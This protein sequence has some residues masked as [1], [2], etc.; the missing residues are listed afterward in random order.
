MAGVYEQILERHGPYYR[1]TIGGHWSEATPAP[2]SPA[3]ERLLGKNLTQQPE[4]ILD[5]IRA[6][7]S[8]I[9]RE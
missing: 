2:G 9:A 8:S 6:E 1:Y 5:S 4:E 3:L 7:R